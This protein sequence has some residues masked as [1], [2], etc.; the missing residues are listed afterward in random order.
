MS[1]D[2]KWSDVFG[3]GNLT[4]DPDPIWGNLSGE[5]AVKDATKAQQ[6]ALEK[7]MAAITG[8]ADKGIALQAPYLKNAAAD[9]EQLRGLVSRG[10]FQQPYGRSFTSQQYQP[11]G[12]SFN[13]LQGSA[14]F[15]PWRPQGGPATFQA[16]ALPGMPTMPTQTAPGPQVRPPATAPGQQITPGQGIDPAK[17]MEVVMRNAP[18][19]IGMTT[20][21]GPS[22]QNGGLM[23][24]NPQT[25]TGN[26]LVSEGYKPAD[27]RM[28]SPQQMW[29]LYLANMATRGRSGPLEGG[30]PGRGLF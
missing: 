27:P 30:M 14:S 2:W 26:P 21:V 17:V 9:Y 16:Q 13:P 18:V 5:N 4:G 29:Q 19:S 12:F 23:G 15:T 6:A 8:A 25:G 3:W 24:Y 20:P 1:R 11:Q 10:F 7:A 28:P 22:P